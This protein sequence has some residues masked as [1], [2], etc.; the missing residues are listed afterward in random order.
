VRRFRFGWVDLLLIMGCLVASPRS[1]GNR[2]HGGTPA[3]SPCC[4]NALAG[5]IDAEKNAGRSA[6][7][8]WRRAR[9]IPT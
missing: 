5:A 8:S 4:C 3:A 1:K 6:R 9:S 2:R 7:N